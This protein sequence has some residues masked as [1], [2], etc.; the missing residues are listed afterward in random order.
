[1]RIIQ[2]S[3]PCVHLKLTHK[4]PTPPTLAY[5]AYSCLPCLLL[6]TPPT[7]AYLA[8]PAY[9][10]LPRLLIKFTHKPDNETNNN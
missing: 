5:L 4:C 9:N 6:P 3:I 10:S 1:M 2:P 7:F 8:Y